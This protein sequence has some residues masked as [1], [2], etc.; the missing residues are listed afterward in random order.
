MPSL[1]QGQ[2]DS[3]RPRI[4]RRPAPFAAVRRG[5]AWSMIGGTRSRRLSSAIETPDGL[6]PAAQRLVAILGKLVAWK[7][8][9]VTILNAML[10]DDLPW[11]PKCA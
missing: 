8:Q 2:Y 9:L 4:F 10:R 5:L 6:P 3:H 11:N 1:R 7:R